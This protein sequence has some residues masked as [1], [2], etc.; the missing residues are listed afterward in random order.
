MISIELWR[1]RIGAF[2]IKSCSR[3]SNAKDS[4]SLL[5]TSNSLN[6]IQTTMLGLVIC[7]L[8]IMG[9]V[10]SNPGPPTVAQGNLL[11]LF[12]NN[13][14]LLNVIAIVLV[15]EFSSYFTF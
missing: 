8:L 2:N 13:L 7:M 1:G 6:L 12:L 14:F 10:E 11:Q 9:G 4:G 3:P 15:H 5:S